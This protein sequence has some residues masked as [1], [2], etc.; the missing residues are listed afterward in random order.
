MTLSAHP[1]HGRPR[2]M[3]ASRLNARWKWVLPAILLL[4]P[5]ASPAQEPWDTGRSVHGQVTFELTCAV[6]HGIDGKGEP[7]AGTQQIV[8]APALTDLARR[9]AGVFP[10]EQ[11]FRIIDGR[12]AGTAHGGEMPA[13]GLLFLHDFQQG[14]P[15]VDYERLAQQRIADLVDYI[16]SIQE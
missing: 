8:A 16:R 13:W 14:L 3:L 6:C 4:S 7:A 11:I 9:N 12:D 2:A 1:D 15:G 5:V 10:S